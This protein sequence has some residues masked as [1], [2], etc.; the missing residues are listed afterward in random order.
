MK[1]VL[2]LD[3]AG[4]LSAVVLGALL[5]ILGRSEW[6]LFFFS[7]LFF[8][9]AAAIVTR[10]KASKKR[11]MNVYEIERGWRNVWAN[12]AVP[13][14]IA[15]LYFLLTLQ[16]G[17]SG[18]ALAVAYL[19]SVAAITADKFSSELGVLSKKVFMLMT[20]MEV[21]AGVSGA[22]SLLGLGVG[23][24]A[25]LLVAGLF[26]F[27]YGFSAVIFTIV[28]VSGFFGDIVDSFFGYFEEHGMGNKFT[29]NIACGVSAA[30]LALALY[31]LVFAPFL[32]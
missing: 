11:A 32:L 25:A 27:S 3:L 17:Y 6:P 18:M 24:L 15:V 16:P 13:L 31:V 1:T 7:M 29:T 26:S 9:I 10:V 4:L 30:V 12:G 5:I 28:V 8:L 22:V 2:T 19:A 20:G 14:F 21:R 23:L